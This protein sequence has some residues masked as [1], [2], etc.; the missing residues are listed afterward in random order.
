MGLFSLLTLGL[1][2]S[3]WA[4]GCIAIVS[5]Y[6]VSYAVHNLFFSP[7]AKVPGPFLAKISGL[8]SFY[9]ACKGDRH[10]W[11][12]QNFQ[13]YGS[14]VRLYPHGVV[15]QSTQ[16][17]ADIYSAKANVQRSKTYEAWQR[18]ER[19]V[20][21]LN[22]SDVSIH[23]RKRRI[24]NTVFTEKS[25]HAAGMFINQHV[26]RWN[27]LLLDLDGNDWSQPKDLAEW[28]DSLVFDILGDL[29]FGRSFEIKEPGEN[30]LKTIPHTIHKYLRL[31]YPMT[32]SPLLDLFL[33]LKPKGLN[34]LLDAI[35]PKDVKNYYR[36][37]EQSVLKRRQLEEEGTKGT[38]QDMFHFL[39]QAK[40]P[41]TGESAYSEQELFAEANLLIVA[42][43]DTT[44]V[45]LCGFFFYVSR[46]KRIYDKLVKEIRTTFDSAEEIVSGS[47]L[48][49][50]QYLRA[51]LDEAMRLAPAGPSE[52]SRTVLPGGQMIDGDF[53]PEGIVVGRSDW[54]SCRS[55]E[56]GD[57]YVYRPERWI[58][59]EE[60]GVTAEDVARTRNSVRPF[61]AGPTSCIG[62]NLAILEL[63]TTTAR[64][65]YRLD[66][67]AAPGSTLGEGAPELGWGRRDRNQY[68]VVDAYISL[69]QGPMLQFKRRSVD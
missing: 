22:T 47:K 62:Q 46:N 30:P 50:C 15:F 60:A 58:V 26:D 64:T 2:G 40:N 21:T 51:C 43:S 41:D 44:S 12:W 25:I 3:Q 28:S 54:S 59:N 68:Q 34:S 7:L 56:F 63:L 39:F 11:I 17:F 57:P 35:T 69:R 67:R 52:L 29:C 45:S 27:E 42:G 20:N 48:S 1:T 61:I 31:T 36:F 5:F 4:F 37:V 13:K 6:F 24:L 55:D 16:A 18:N 33:W 10:I 49:S 38:R 19:D 23:R 66:M 65:L 53:Y 9:H 14:K 32:R 8:P